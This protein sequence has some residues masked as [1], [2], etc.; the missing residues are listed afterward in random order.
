MASWLLICALLLILRPSQAALDKQ[1]WEREC[2]QPT[3][4]RCK[5]Y[6]GFTSD[7]V[8][9]MDYWKG[10]NTTRASFTRLAATCHGC[11]HLKLIDG[12]LYIAGAHRMRAGES[13]DPPPLRSAPRDRGGNGVGYMHTHNAG[14]YRM[15]PAL[16]SVVAPFARMHARV[17]SAGHVWGRGPHVGTH[18]PATAMAEAL[19][20]S[21]PLADTQH[22]LSHAKPGAVCDALIYVWCCSP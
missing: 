3:A 11:M 14:V 22:A 21:P 18:R 1:H 10:I 5:R 6:E 16:T 2:R 12:D 13:C 9:V 7:S 19:L 8:R 17:I 20:H 4:Q 15:L